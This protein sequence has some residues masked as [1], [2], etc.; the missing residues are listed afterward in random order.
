MNVNELE[1]VRE[2]EREKAKRNKSKKIMME[3]RLF[4]Q[5]STNLL[6]WV[7]NSWCYYKIAD[8]FCA[9][10][11]S[12]IFVLFLLLWPIR[13]LLTKADKSPSHKVIRQSSAG[14]FVFFSSVFHSYAW[15]T[16]L[17]TLVGWQLACKAWRPIKFFLL[18]QDNMD[19]QIRIKVMHTNKK[20]CE[21]RRRILRDQT[22]FA[23]R[24]LWFVKNRL[25]IP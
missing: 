11:W 14:F 9:N 13:C 21:R 20:F 18:H 5:I 10:I 12:S 7:M 15:N 23:L 3:T 24:L 25:H 16:I 8:L 1:G 4:H 2:I 19:M 6:P 22:D 17:F